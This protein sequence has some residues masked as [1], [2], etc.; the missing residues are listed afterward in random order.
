MDSTGLTKEHYVLSGDVGGTN[1]RLGLFTFGEGRPDDKLFEIY[2]NSQANDFEE[3]IQRFLDAH[4]VEISAACFGIAGPIEDGRVK[5][6]NL[7][8]EIA[9][10][11]IKERFGWE[12]VRLI[13]DVEANIRAV[14]LLEKKDLLTL[15]EGKFQKGKNIGMASPGTGLGEALMIE[16]ESRYVPVA[17]EGGHVEFAPRDER[18]LEL[19]R[20]LHKKFGHVSIERVVSGPG[21]T[22]I[23]NCLRESSNHKEPGWLTKLLEEEDP[24]LVIT[25][26]ALEKR[27]S[28]CLQAIHMFVSVFGAVAG[29]LALVGLTTGGMYLGGGIPPKILPFLTTGRFMAAFKD[30]GRFEGLLSRIPVY[31]IL[32]DTAALI[33]AADCA[34]SYLDFS[35]SFLA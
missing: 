10:D 35:W 32:N 16:H 31:V 5:A 24:P 2:E 19:W 14:P 23:Y 7:P 20:Y 3:L 6:T 1:T 18:Q 30:K 34:L 11:T 12:H 9:E 27:D 28:I 33:G 4:P 8:W 26:I 13:N 22:D 15:N 29:N 25:R 17:T 21:L